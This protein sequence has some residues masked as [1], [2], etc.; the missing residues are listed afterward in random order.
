MLTR[1]LTSLV[2]TA[3]LIPALIFS[4]TVF[5][6]AAIA[7]VSVLSI[8]EILSCIGMKKRIGLTLPIYVFAI[9][10]PFLVRYMES[11]V[12][13]ALVAFMVAAGYAVYLFAHVVWSHGAISFADG[14]AVYTLALYILTALT[15]IIYVRDFERGGQYL[16]LLIFLGAWITDIFA[17]FT[18]YFFGKHKLIEDVS[19]KKTVEGSIG[20]IVFCAISFG[21]FGWIVNSFFGQ[22]ANILFLIVCGVILSLVSQIGDLIM[23]VIKRQYKIKDFGKIFPGHGGMLDRFDSILAV[24]LGLAAIC[25][26][27]S[28]TNLSLM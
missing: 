19:P 8:Y 13:Y 23:S 17:Y 5:F 27:I 15:A 4:N 20:G 18:G 3:V 22:N 16:Y 1:I 28:L 21:V 25:T 2:A 11:T 14:A 10:S 6:T 9:A 7:L 24:S 26:F 12:Q